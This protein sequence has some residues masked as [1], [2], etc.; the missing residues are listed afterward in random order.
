MFC[1][2]VLLDASL[3]FKKWSPSLQGYAETNVRTSKIKALLRGG[4]MT[5]HIT[6][7]LLIPTVNLQLRTL[8]YKAG[9]DPSMRSWES[10]CRTEQMVLDN[11]LRPLHLEGKP[12]PLTKITVS[13]LTNAFSIKQLQLRYHPTS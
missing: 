4:P 6:L 7:Y 5:E 3:V 2:S 9:K 8:E 12:W 1:S 11:N 13:A 10:Q